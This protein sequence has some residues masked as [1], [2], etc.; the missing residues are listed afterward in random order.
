M[1]QKTNCGN[2]IEYFDVLRALACL[3]VIFIHVSGMFVDKNIGSPDFWFA[4]VIDG[5]SRVAVPIFVMLSGALMLDK[6][7]RFTKEKW[8]AHIKKMVVF[9]VFWSLAYNGV[10]LIKRIIFHEALRWTE[11]LQSFIEG[12]FHLWF[13][14]LIIGL[15]LIVPL[16]RLWVKE[17]N[18][19]YVAYF[20]LLSFV[21]TSLLPQ[22]ISIGRYFETKAAADCLERILESSLNLRYVGGY[23]G[24]FL[25]GW[26]LHNF[27][28][29]NRKLLYALGILGFLVT[30]FGTYFL[31]VSTGTPVQMYG[32][33]SVN[34]LL[35]A[36]ALFVFMKEKNAHAGKIIASISKNSLGIY[37]SH[38][39]F[40]TIL[41]LAA[42]KLHINQVSAFLYI[43]AVF[44]IAFAASY[45]LTALFSKIPGLKKVI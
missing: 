23:T 43:P 1:E 19:K 35:C 40:I 42:E 29:K 34:V 9:F 18:K 4:N 36:A 27:E 6:N 20:L 12:P 7:Y 44:I 41:E 31:S 5:A 24:C 45:V 26:Y 16:L 38:V 39:L 11:L 22:M 8:L 13:I 17:E 2:R 21:F 32:Q 28:I 3:M 14:Y 30:V 10:F 25:L 33:L 15:Y 37:A